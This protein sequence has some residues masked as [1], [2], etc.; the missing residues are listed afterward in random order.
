V[1]ELIKEQDA[2]IGPAIITIVT[3]VLENL[4]KLDYYAEKWRQGNFATRKHMGSDMRHKIL[5]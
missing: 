4:N 5:L 2:P 1:C 3:D